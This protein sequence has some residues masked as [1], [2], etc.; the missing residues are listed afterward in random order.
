MRNTVKEFVKSCRI[1]QQTKARN[2]KPFG[3]LQPIEPPSNKWEVITMDFVIPLPETKNGNS[4][5]LNVVCKLSKMIRII[6]IHYN[7]NATAVAMKFKEHIYRNHGLPTKIIS[8]RDSLFMSKFWKE[9]FRSLGTKLAPSTAYHPQ[10]DGQSEIA[11]RKVEEM[12][13]AFANYRKDNW[14]EHLIDFEVAYNSAVNSTT[15]STPFFINY[16]MHPKTLP[17][18]GVTSLNPTVESFLETIKKT[19]KF[20]HDRIIH[21]N[22]KMA[23]DANKSRISHTFRE[24]SEV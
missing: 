16:G 22:K 19:T 9:L 10:T 14:D 12:I 13:R 23:E 17:I 15:L 5:I 24:G 2:H 1:C 18:E 3:L 20:T 11:N 6:P 8:D 7:I 21:Q 4:G